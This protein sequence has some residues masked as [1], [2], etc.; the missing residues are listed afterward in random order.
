M[1][2]T[3]V[4]IWNIWQGKAVLFLSH[5][6]HYSY[7]YTFDLSCT[8]ASKKKSDC[9]GLTKVN[10]CFFSGTTKCTIAT[11]WTREISSMR[12]PNM[13]ARWLLLTRSFS[14]Y[15]RVVFDTVRFT[16]TFS[17]CLF[18]CLWYVFT[19]LTYF[20]KHYSSD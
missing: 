13:I 3:V 12:I 11:L 4:F 1:I 9:L 7:C 20:W 6:K 10:I 16:F 14:M 15:L 2:I 18:G 19:F 5:T 8:Y 17:K